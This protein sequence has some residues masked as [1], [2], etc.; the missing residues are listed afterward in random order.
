MSQIPMRSLARHTARSVGRRLAAAEG[1]GAI[2]R[3]AVRGAPLIGLAA[4][5]GAVL[6]MRSAGEPD[7]A[8]ARFEGVARVLAS[9]RPTAANLGWALDRGREVVAGRPG[10]TPREAAPALLELAHRLAEEQRA[11]D[12]RMAELGAALLEPGDRVLTHCNT[13]GLATGGI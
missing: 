12:T 13:G 11:A 9:S 10:A 4:A 7:G 6:G 1:A 5:Y 8:A 3:R 2:R